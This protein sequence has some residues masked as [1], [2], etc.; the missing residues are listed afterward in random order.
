MVRITG[1]ELKDSIPETLTVEINSVSLIPDSELVI[2]EGE[3]SEGVI[4]I[5]I[6]RKKVARLLGKNTRR[7]KPNGVEPS[8]AQSAATEEYAEEGAEEVPSETP[9]GLYVGKERRKDGKTQ[10][11]AGFTNS[12]SIMNK[13]PR[14]T[15]RVRHPET[16]HKVWPIWENMGD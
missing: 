7:R 5:P 3:C 11:L 9:R 13:P 4:T 1:K 12:G 8:T 10:R 6:Y 14:T 2:L 15:R 16:G